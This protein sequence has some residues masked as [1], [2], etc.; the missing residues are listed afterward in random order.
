MKYSAVILAAGS[1]T[2]LGL[3]YNK[4][5][6]KLDDETIIEK[7]IHVFQ[8]DQDCAEIIL[9]ISKND[10]QAMKALFHD[11]VSYVYGGVTRQESSYF[12]VSQAKE[13]IV[14]IHDGARPFVTMSELNRCKETMQYADACLLMVPVKDTIKIVQEGK[15]T[16]TPNRDL[17]M[18]ALTPQCF[19]R[20]LIQQCLQ[21]A[22][23][24]H[25]VFSDDASVIEKLSDSD[26][27]VVMGEY[28]NIKITTKEDL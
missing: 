10:E 28:S 18:A 16:T 20:K 4:L 25:E 19:K 7:T 23:K 6:H 21:T 15:V 12:G 1:G 11:Q 27:H 22:M 3:G 2:R 13:E 17:L 14:M 5:L 24:S 26:V 8:Y 9:V